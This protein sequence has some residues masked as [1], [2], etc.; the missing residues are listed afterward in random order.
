[1]FEVAAIRDEYLES[2]VWNGLDVPWMGREDD[3]V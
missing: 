2:C 1:M 3:S